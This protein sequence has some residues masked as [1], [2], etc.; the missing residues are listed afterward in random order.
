VDVVD[1]DATRTTGRSSDER[2]LSRVF[3]ERERARIQAAPDPDLEVWSLWAAKEAAF[4]VIYK[5]RSEPPVFH[6]AR[7]EVVDDPDSPIR[8]LEYEE[9]SVTL[10][11]TRCGSRLLAWAW[12]GPTT[13]IFVGHAEAERVRSRL[14]LSPE[15]ESWVDSHFSPEERSAIHSLPSALVRLAAREDAARL[16]GI[17]ARDLRIVCPPGHTG[18]R[19]PYLMVGDEMITAAD[20]SLSHDGPWIAW[21]IR[22]DDS[23]FSEEASG[24]D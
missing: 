16:L 3:S 23:P 8:T 12:S 20:V 11:L 19:P 14:G 1:L 24:H 5:A 18:L 4:K 22:L 15:L 21:A 7:F 17:W 13:E 10:N 2:F 6:H 9:H